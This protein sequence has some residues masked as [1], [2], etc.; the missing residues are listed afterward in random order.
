MANVTWTTVEDE[1]GS[2]GI[3]KV[4]LM[5]GVAI[6]AAAVLLL[7]VNAANGSTQL[8]VTVEEFHQQQ[9]RFM[10]RDL[11]MGALVVGDSIQ[12][13]QLT[14]TTSRLEFAVVDTYNNPQYEMQV[15]VMNEPKPDLLQH[16][17]TALI[18]GHVG[19]DGVFYVNPG[20]LLLKCPTRYEE[21]DP[22]QHIGK[23]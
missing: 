13:I 1:V 17:A 21:A 5:V 16:E 20:G 18:E 23:Q 10:G 11:R 4:K 12:Y 9:E 7:I 6:L 15:V 19:E 3:N 14:D 8:Y 2:G 22:A